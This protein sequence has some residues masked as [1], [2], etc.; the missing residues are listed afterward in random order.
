MDSWHDM[1]LDT[2]HLHE[3]ARELHPLTE[4]HPPAPRY[5]PRPPRQTVIRDHFSFPP[6]DHALLAELQARCLQSGFAVTK[7]E[8]VRAGLHILHSLPAAAL[9]A[10]HGRLQKVK[11]GRGARSS[12]SPAPS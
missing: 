11:T 4:P 1:T 9:R 5:P 10:A 6:D 8:L 3:L 12:S 2:D 7:S